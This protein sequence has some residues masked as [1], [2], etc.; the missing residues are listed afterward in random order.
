[1]ED[2][3]KKNIIAANKTTNVMKKILTILAFTGLVSLAKAE[4]V[5]SPYVLDEVA[6]EKTIAGAQDVT[7]TF[8]S[9][10]A[11]GMALSAM[12]APVQA[13]G[14]GS[15]KAGKSAVAAILLDF[16]LGGLGIH[17]FYL[18]TAT[19]TGIGYI[20]TLG[21]ICG[22]VPFVDFIVLI[23]NSSDISKYEDNPKFFM[24]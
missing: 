13:A 24:W 23:V 16:F 12:N 9:A 2:N 10:D 19:L 1:L 11:Q 8:M 21:G 6:I 4:G 20:L 14:Q 3:H 17:R 18:G 7:A 5:S 22:V 15:L